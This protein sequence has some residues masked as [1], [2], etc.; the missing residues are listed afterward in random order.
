M[1][2]QVLPSVKENNS[3]NIKFFHFSG[4]NNDTSP[5]TFVLRHT[6]DDLPFPCRYIKIVPLQSWGCTYNFSIWFVGLKGSDDFDEIKKAVKW[7]DTVSHV[8][9]TL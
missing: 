5:E 3:I 9:Y 1:H 7:F 6:L 8:Y 2:Y 4:L